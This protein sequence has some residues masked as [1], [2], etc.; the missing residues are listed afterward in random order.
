[1]P[2]VIRFALLCILLE[3]VEGTLRSVEGTL[4]SLKVLQVLL[5]ATSGGHSTSVS[6]GYSNYMGWILRYDSPGFSGV[7]QNWRLL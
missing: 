2:E 5:A 4:S 6:G 3:T 7:A 1:M